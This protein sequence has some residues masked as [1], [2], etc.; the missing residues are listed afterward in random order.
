MTVI[1][2]KAPRG[3]FFIV[4]ISTNQLLMSKHQL[5]FN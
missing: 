2:K 4:D 1:R 5:I 3:A